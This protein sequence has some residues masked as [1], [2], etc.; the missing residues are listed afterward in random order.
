MAETADVA[1]F[2]TSR[3]MRLRSASKKLQKLAIEPRA[4][5]G[6]SGAFARSDMFQTQSFQ[7]LPALVGGA[8][9]GLSASLVLLSHGRVAGISGIFGGLLRTQPTD[10]TFRGWFLAGLLL[11]GLVARIAWPESTALGN[12]VGLGLTAL[13]GLLVGFGTSMGNGCTSGHGVCGLSRQSPRSLSATLTFMATGALA[14]F[15]LRQASGGAQ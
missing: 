13:A 10:T 15:A 6:T 1:S 7:P 11:S 4:S 14:V 12:H 3:F 9:I 2:A 8:L 5:D